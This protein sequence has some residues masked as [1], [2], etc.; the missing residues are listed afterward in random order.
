MAMSPLPPRKLD[1]G[2][3][4]RDGWRAF[5]RNPWSFLLFGLLLVG[6]EL[7][8]HLLL[9]PRLPFAWKPS[10]WLT[11]ATP[12]A[13]SPCRIDAG[14]LECRLDLNSVNWPRLLRQSLDLLRYGLVV[15]CQSVLL[16]GLSLLLNLWG[17]SGLIR[18]SW[19]ALE[20]RR[21]QFADFSH[22]DA[23]ALLRL[24]LPSL[25]LRWGLGLVFAMAG[26]LAVVLGG[27][28][29]WLALVPLLAALA[30]LIYLS[31]SQFFLPQLALLHDPNALDTL[32]AGQRQVDRH[33]DQVAGLAVLSFVVLVAGALLGLGF[34]LFIAWPV[35]V[36]IQTAAYRQLFG[37]TDHTGFSSKVIPGRDLGGQA[38][39]AQVLNA[40]VL[41]ARDRG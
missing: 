15:L 3:A 22:W 21:P 12:W 10:A 14:V 38:L 2:P 1:L 26:L 40:Q 19:L 4:L 36:C 29:P 9:Q 25:L 16:G 24:A 30:I 6:L 20:G 34:G 39:S 13:W 32:Q 8:L 18:G 27:L 41:S 35:V 5:A 28:Q 37:P 23:R 17:T 11:G 31:V 33:W 7:A